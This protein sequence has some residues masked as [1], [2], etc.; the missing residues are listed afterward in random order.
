[1]KK[2]PPGVICIENV[3][4]FFII[5][6]LIVVYYLYYTHL[7]N[8]SSLHENNLQSNKN[9]NGRKIMNNEQ[10]FISQTPNFPYTNLPPISPFLPPPVPG[11]VLLDPY[12]PP[13]RDERYLIPQINFIPPG[14]VPINVSTN[15][16]AVDTSYR[17]MGILEPMNCKNNSEKILP[18]MGR[19][20]FTNRNKWQYYT[21]NNQ[22][23]SVKLPLIV[24]GRSA[25]NEYGID[26]LTG[27]ERVRIQ[28]LN[29]VYKVTLYDND[30]IKYLPFI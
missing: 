7:R 21:I 14:T 27:R 23:N 29:D 20:V 19:P 25:T 10:I 5:I 11:D 18:L 16:G 17:Q 9:N 1:M 12:V 2:C 30:T 4:I 8:I 13:L 24:K 26:E 28:G 22:Y 6:V 15:I 3:T